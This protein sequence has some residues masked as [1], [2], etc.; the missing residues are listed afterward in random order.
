MERSPPIGSVTLNIDLNFVGAA[1]EP[2]FALQTKVPDVTVDA[3]GNIDLEELDA[4]AWI[5]L[6]I[7]TEKSDFK[8]DIKFK[9]D[10]IN[11]L[12]VSENPFSRKKSWSKNSQFDYAFVDKDRLILYIYYMNKNGEPFSRY[13]LKYKI[14]GDNEYYDPAIKNIAK[15]ALSPRIPYDEP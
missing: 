5:V 12:F 7:V 10:A 13:G 8:D 1:R 11:A 3:D 15:P 6:K 4:S 14:D 9:K 2:T